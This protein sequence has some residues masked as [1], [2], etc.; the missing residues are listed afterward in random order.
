MSLLWHTFRRLL[1]AVPVLLGVTVITFMLVHITPGDPARTVLGPTASQAD[2]LN[3]THKLGL[4]R[5]LI[6]QYWHY[7]DGLL[8]GDL[9]Q[10]VAFQQPA[11]TLVWQ[12]L[13]VTLVLTIGSFVIAVA[14]S[15]PF[16]IIAARYRGRRPDVITRFLALL[17]VSAPSFWVGI[18]L[19][20]LFAYKIRLF[21][22]AGLQTLWTPTAIPY[23]VLP[24]VTLALAQVALSA[25]TLRASLLEVLGKD[26]MRTAEAK[27]LSDLR[28]LCVHGLRN[29]LIPVIT[30]MG[31]QVA[32]L[33]GG[34]VVTETVFAL[35]GIG[36]LSVEAIQ[37]GDMPLVQ[38]I[39]LLSAVAVVIINLG[40]DL[41]Y[42]IVNPRAS[43]G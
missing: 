6:W 37:N 1:G 42:R 13:P 35:P 31:L 2:V 8:H 14:L 19:I 4:D 12:R 16:G 29:A 40:T 3:L 41:L 38:G 17:G 27:G 25:R 9:G 34:A 32:A 10:S 33:F 30:V 18:M 28:V 39:V 36:R 21:P 23:F 43:D 26:Y 7:L 20:Y 5:P 24:C 11:R 22:A 15:I